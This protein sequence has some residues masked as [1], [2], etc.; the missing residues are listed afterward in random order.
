MIG[1]IQITGI[2]DYSL[3]KI[4]LMGQKQ[5]IIKQANMYCIS[6]CK[7]GGGVVDLKTRQLAEDMMVV[8]LFIDV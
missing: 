3:A 1:Q 2:S 4:N 7:R 6:M 5:Q 8:E